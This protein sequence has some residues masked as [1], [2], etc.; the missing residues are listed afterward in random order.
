MADNKH[1]VIIDGNN[2]STIEGFYDEF[3]EKFAAP[4]YFGRNLDALNDIL[5]D[6]SNENTIV[7]WENANKSK[8]DLNIIKNDEALFEVIVEIFNDHVQLIL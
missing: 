3:T 5:Y 8:K 7:I 4:S 2:F 6:I 1:F